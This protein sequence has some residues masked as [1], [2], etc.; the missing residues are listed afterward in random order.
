MKILSDNVI[1][2]FDIDW[3]SDFYGNEPQETFYVIIGFCNGGGNYGV[4]RQISGKMKEVFTIVG[5][6]VDKEDTPNV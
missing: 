1:T 6:Y 2:H 4:N 5:Y 3:Y